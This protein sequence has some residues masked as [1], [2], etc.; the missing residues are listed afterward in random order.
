MRSEDIFRRVLI[1]EVL[2]LAFADAVKLDNTSRQD[3]VHGEFGQ[4]E[5][6]DTYAP[7][8]EQW[9]NNPA[10]S[11][12]IE[13]II[14]VLTVETPWA[15]NAGFQHAMIDY[16]RRQLIPDI[17]VIAKDAA[18]IQ[19]ALS[20]R[21]ANAGLLP[22]FGFPTRVRTLY[23]RWP[24]SNPWP[25]ETG[26][27][28]R[29]LDLA[30][31]Q[32]APGSQTVK[33]KAVHTAVGVVE[34]RPTGGKLDT[35]HGFNPPLTQ[36][37]DHPI[38]LC[39]HCL[40]VV[41]LPATIRP[42]EGGK[43][44]V[45]QICPVCNHP[46]ASLRSIDARE[47]KG[48]FTDLEPED[49][50]GQFEWNP[51]STQPSLSINAASNGMA[52]VANCAITA[53]ND[54][55]ISVNDNGGK[56][57]FDFQKARV[58]GN[59]KDGAYAVAVYETDKAPVAS[60]EGSVGVSGDSYRIALLSRRRTDV[61]LV[62][63]TDWPKGVFA[64]PTTVEGRAA[65]YSFAFWLRLAAGAHLDVDALEL[66]AGFRSLPDAHYPVI[67]QAFLCDQLE[68]GAG[69]CRFL[70][71]SAEFQKLL[72]QGEQRTPGSIAAKW[73]DLEHGD[74]CD[75]SCN[76]CLRDF[77]NLPYHGLLDWRLALDMVRIAHA[78]TAT[79]DL[80][81]PVG[82]ASNTWAPLVSAANA[83][84]PATMKRLGYGDPVQFAN[85]SGYMKQNP[86]NKAIT[87]VCHP[88]WQ[89][90]HPDWLAAR[91][92][93]KAKYPDY[94]VKPMNPFRLLRRPAEYV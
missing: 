27:V 68:N 60:K 16:L 66:Q 73:I 46:D 8:I 49:F 33:D 5:D 15:G 25:P 52:S 81:S 61:L 29:N 18:Y 32:F 55:I 14:Q 41:P 50:D 59:A 9:L 64:N 20:E 7:D 53:L 17:T 72:A 74:E 93:A 85:L 67:G 82:A 83:P 92:D 62:S 76:L 3:N 26:T 45:K 78:P 40:A 54:Q 12:H 56:G 35:Q 13:R 71:N 44:P 30:I 1:K 42:A 31:S 43:E 75:T 2:R 37:N 77:H 65:W 94:K 19:D 89:D 23:T 47:P 51:R 11:P 21:L 88:L 36:G 57:G 24:A 86:R 63:I 48:F 34:L 90:D 69:Y 80:V 38:G 84:I 87:I 28:D 79:I 58:Y 10:N 6:W 22:M 39:E 91:A 4:A 70:S